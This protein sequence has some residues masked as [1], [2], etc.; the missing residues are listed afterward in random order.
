VDQNHQTQQT[1]N[2]ANQ[3]RSMGSGNASPA[4][5]AGPPTGRI[6]S[7]SS[8]YQTVDKGI[9]TATIPEN[10]RELEQENSVWY[11]PN[12][13]YGSAKGQAIF[14]HAVNLG[15]A[16]TRSQN[17]QQATEEFVN[18]LKQ[19]NHL[20]VHTG[21]E[22]MNIDKRPGRLITLENVNEATGRPEFVIIIATQLRNGSL[23]Y[24]IAVSPK[25]DYKALQPTFAT[26]LGS[27]RLN[28]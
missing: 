28:D 6:E 2:Q 10:W 4:D 3:P 27:I 8:R 26:I 23:F 9:F 14:T 22:Q 5:Y 25:D 24:M 21:F 18:G 13:G 1:M 16:Q 19:S 7:P 15:I 20:K 12:G 11:A 17:A